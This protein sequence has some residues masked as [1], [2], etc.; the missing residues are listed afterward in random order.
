MLINSIL[1]EHVLNVENWDNIYMHD[2]WIALVGAA[3]GK[4]VYIDQPLGL[5]RQH[6]DNTVGLQKKELS[7]RFLHFKS[8][9]SVKDWV[10]MQK[11]VRDESRLY[12][13]ELTRIMPENHTN[14]DVVRRFAT[15]DQER[16]LN[17]LI[18]YYKNHLF[19][20]YR[21]ILIQILFI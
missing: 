18:F 16:K 1:R 14:Y 13:K 17:R 15:I 8:L 11:R 2:W 3:I 10:N 21:P 5:Y 4:M 7:K 9:A 20:A 12:A 19:L 6:M